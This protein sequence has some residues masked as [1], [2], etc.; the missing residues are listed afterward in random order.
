MCTEMKRHMDQLCGVVDFTK[1]QVRAKEPMVFYCETRKSSEVCAICMIDHLGVP[2]ILDEDERESGR[3]NYLT[4]VGEE[5]H[6][7][8]SQCDHKVH[9]ACLKLI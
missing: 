4:H 1:D 8:C 5:M 6:V 7:F 3:I 9:K 2:L